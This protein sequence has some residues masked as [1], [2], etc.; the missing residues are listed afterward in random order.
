[1]S[2]EQQIEQLTE[3]I[4]RTNPTVALADGRTMLAAELDFDNAAHF[5]AFALQFKDEFKA[6]ILSPQSNE[7][8]ESDINDDADLDTLLLELEDDEDV[9][10]DVEVTR[11]EKQKE[12][13]DSLTKEIDKLRERMKKK[14]S[15]ETWR[16]LQSKT[17]QITD[18]KNRFRREKDIK[19]QTTPARE[20]P[21][22][23][24]RDS[25]RFRASMEF[26]ITR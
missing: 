15:A 6:V 9:P 23:V 20:I 1:M 11:E 3:N 24:V 25:R 17:E 8:D 14:F 10:D 18:L 21:C 12:Q 13:I 22:E 19:Q 16:E 4:I 7:V 26:D 2:L 5:E